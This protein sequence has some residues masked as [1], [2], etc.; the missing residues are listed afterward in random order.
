MSSANV[1]CNVT[2]SS[3][4]NNSSVAEATVSTQLLCSTDSE[5]LV[6]LQIHFFGFGSPVSSMPKSHGTCCKYFL[7]VIPPW[8]PLHEVKK[9]EDL[10][11]HKYSINRISTAYSCAKSVKILCSVP[12]QLILIKF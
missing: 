7:L 1:K 11:G 3:L 10:L 12:R 4:T 9:K 6:S 8:I 5:L 2:Y